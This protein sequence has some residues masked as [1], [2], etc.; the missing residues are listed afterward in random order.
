[1]A[2]TTPIPIFCLKTATGGVDLRAAVQRVLD[3]HWY[4]L[5]AEVAAFEQEF[6]QYT[7]VEHCVSVGNGTDALELALRASGVQRGDVVATVANAGYYTSTVVDAIGATPLYVDI[8]PDTL[9]MCTDSLANALAHR[10]KAVMVTHLY[11]RLANMAALLDLA[12]TAGVP[13]IEDCA[14]AVG[15]ERDGQRAG[16][17]GVMGCFSFYPTKNLGAAG[18]GGAVVTSSPEL[19]QRLRTLRQYGWTQKYHVGV[20][21]GRNSRLD[22]IQAAVLRTRLP[23]LPGWNASRRAIARAYNDA[24]QHLPVQCPPSFEDDAVAHLYVLQLDRRD[25]LRVFLTESAIATDVHYPIPDHLQA[26][27]M[28]NTALHA[29][30]DNTV[31]ACKRIVT[32]PC[33]PGMTDQQVN[34]VIRAVTNF[35]DR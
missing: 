9:T 26:V 21:G 10:P 4:I 31:A 27:R 11:G 16:S 34:R 12:D 14:Q 18:D 1:M 29:S 7:R 23:H 22:E 24:F 33:Y 5:G 32:L 35:F 30:L 25:D 20:P 2:D 6:A 19:A 3:S 28:H 8:D 17:W 15:A 13:V